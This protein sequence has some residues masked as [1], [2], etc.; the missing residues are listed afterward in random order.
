MWR[1]EAVCRCATFIASFSAG[2]SHVS[3]RL[4]GCE[5]FSRNSSWCVCAAAPHHFL[6]VGCAPLWALRHSKSLHASSIST[7]PVGT[8]LRADHWNVLFN[9]PWANKEGF[10]QRP[11]GHAS[12]SG[13]LM[14]NWAALGLAGNLGCHSWATVLYLRAFLQCKVERWR[15]EIPDLHTMLQNTHISPAH[16]S[17]GVPH[18]ADTN[19]DSQMCNSD[20]TKTKIDCGLQLLATINKAYQRIPQNTL[21]L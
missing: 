13:S 12:F 8:Q 2:D 9:W 4:W 3:S 14:S 6:F 1:L 5:C 15:K 7:G 20:Q 17:G 18:Q 16:I 19:P 10:G 21:S 11:K